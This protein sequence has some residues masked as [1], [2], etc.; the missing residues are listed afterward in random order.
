MY[1][2]E[3]RRMDV[4][5]RTEKDGCISTNREGWVYQYEQRMMGVSVRTENDGCISTNREGWVY[6]YEQRMIDGEGVSSVIALS[7]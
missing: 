2:Y 6:Q 1:Q 5:V 3:Q 7:E 4:S